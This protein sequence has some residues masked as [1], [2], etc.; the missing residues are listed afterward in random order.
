M[1]RKYMIFAAAAIF[2]G[3]AIIASTVLFNA[4]SGIKQP[5]SSTMSCSEQGNNIEIYDTKPISDAFA[6]KD[7]SSL[8][9]F[10]KKIYSKAAE[11][12]SK[13]ITDDMAIYDKELAVH[14]YMV[15]NISY[16]AGNMGIEEKTDENS[17]NPYGALING[18]AI[19]SGYTST[20][21]MF[22]DMLDIENTVVTGK[23]D[24]GEEHAWNMI[25]LD[26]EWYHVDVTWDDPIPE[27]EQTG[28]LH[29]YF[30]VT[31][32]ELINNRHTW[33]KSG[34]PSANADK[35]AFKGIE[36]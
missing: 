8:S 5:V 20:F 17:V 12:Y 33:D 3:I 11:I 22:M 9:D 31:D 27:S 26:G 7:S 25:K 13:I 35:Y 29:K 24:K 2:M 36:I 15:K 28:I 4:V 34:Y 30:N 10:D 18:K 16:D 19:C 14:D 1:K 6:A 21:K 32:N 23:N